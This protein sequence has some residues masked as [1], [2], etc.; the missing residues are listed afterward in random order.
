[1]SADFLQA[2]KAATDGLLYMSETDEPF[3][4]VHWHSSEPNLTSASLRKHIGKSSSAPVEEV[5][6]EEFFQDLIEDQDWHDEKAKRAVQQ[7]RQLLVVLK[8]NLAD[9]KVFKIGEVQI[10]IYLIGRA[11]DGDWAGIK[12]AAIET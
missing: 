6:L 1:M 10:D 9:L 11:T 8:Q 3:E 2:L 7:Y 4:L 5:D 12:T